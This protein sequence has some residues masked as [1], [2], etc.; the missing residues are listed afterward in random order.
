[1]VT[2]V[3][4]HLFKPVVYHSLATKS[5]NVWSVAIITLRGKIIIISEWGIIYSFV[6]YFEG[7]GSREDRNGVHVHTF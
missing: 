1:M 5:Q 3:H 4:L 2:L 6:L 7:F